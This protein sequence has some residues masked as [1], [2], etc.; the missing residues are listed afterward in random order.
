MRTALLL[1]C[2]ALRGLLQANLGNLAG[3]EADWRLALAVDPAHAAAREL[4]NR[5]KSQQ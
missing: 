4:L 3:A 1:S 2:C 5:L